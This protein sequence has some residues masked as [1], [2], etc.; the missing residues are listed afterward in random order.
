[1]TKLHSEEPVFDERE[2]AEIISVAAALQR[3]HGQRATLSDL[4]L[5]AMEAGIDPRFVRE[6]VARRRQARFRPVVIA[7]SAPEP[8]EVP[9]PTLVAALLFIPFGAFL[10]LQFDFAMH[11]AGTHV[12]FWI[13]AAAGPAVFGHLVSPRRSL[14]AFALVWPYVVEFFVMSS[15]N[16]YRVHQWFWVIFW[17]GLFQGV[18]AL[19]A[20]RAHRSSWVL[21]VLARP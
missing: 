17:F 4:E 16:Y 15:G 13:L 1:M 3:E 11:W 2:Q 18:I 5:A 21:R 20:H 19:M 7:S 9:W 12:G 8:I 10:V 6:A 14:G